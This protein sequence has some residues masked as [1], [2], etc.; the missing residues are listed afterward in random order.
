MPALLRS[1][2]PPALVAGSHGPA[3][4]SAYFGVR[5]ESAV[6]LLEARE[7]S[8]LQ[9]EE[10]LRKALG[11]QRSLLNSMLEPS[12]ALALDLRTYV[13]PETGS[14][15]V[16]LLGRSWSPDAATAEQRA[17]AFAH[18]IQ[19][20]LPRHVT[21]VAVEDPAELA[22]LIWPFGA[23]AVTETGAI[24]RREVTALPTRP[25]AKV[26]YYFSVLPF[27]WAEDDWISLYSTLSQ[28][29]VRM[30]LSVGLLPVA[31]PR[32]FGERLRTMA[33]YYG[34]LASED[35]VKGGLYHGQQKLAPD[36]FAVDAQKVFNDYSRR[37]ADRAY[38]MRIALCAEGALPPGVPEAVAAAVSPP[39]VAGGS[40]LTQDRTSSAYE[41]REARQEPE[42]SVARWNL[43]A[44]D[45]CTYGGAAEIWQ[46]PDPPSADLRVLCNLGDA[47]DASCAFRFPVAVDGTVPGFKVRRGQ[48]GHVESYATSGPAIVLGETTAG[49]TLAL[50]LGSL[51]KHALV[52]GGTGSG[53]TTTVLEI[54][55]QLW[56]EHEVP[57]LVI[58]PVNADADDYRKLLT[59]PGFE[60]LEVFTVGDEGVH[61]LRFNPFEVPEGALVSEHMANLLSCFKAAF[62][63]WEPLPSIYEEA[64]NLTYMSAGILP[65]ERPDG[66]PRDWP[67]A[68]EF[69]KAMGEATA[70]L[71]YAGEVKSN[72]EAASI[73]RAQQLASGTCASTF[74]TT[75]SL[76]LAALLDHPVVIELK[77]LGAGDEQSL[78][79]AFL[80][81]AMTE[82]YQAV[83]G[84]SPTLRHVT[85]IEEAHRL[86]ARP[87]GGG[88]QNT[89][90]AKEKAAEGFANTLAENRK[91]GEGV[92]IAEQLPTKLV[93][94]AVKNTNLKMMHRLTA[95]DERKYLGETMGFDDSQSRFA[96]RLQT[97]EALVYADDFA[98]ATLVG[99]KPQLA[100]TVP[101]VVARQADPPFAA[102]AD[103]RAQCLY[104]GAALAVVRQPA[105][106]KRIR[107][108][109]GALEQEGLTSAQIAERWDALVGALRGTV[110]SYPVLPQE[111]PGVSD[112]AYCIFLHALA[113]KNMRF[114][115]RWASAVAARLGLGRRA[116]EEVGV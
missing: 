28:A 43:E 63:L 72:I 108:A 90:Q 50:P 67:T 33:T 106:G 116:R 109:A 74:L 35:T 113:T 49:G 30:F 60:A 66:S 110:T 81:N 53:K 83:R 9:R 61:P 34:R 56:A 15:D 8:G 7:Y 27:N 99:V 75:R 88:D 1:L 85:V 51:T 102:C 100:S 95:E 73:R 114:S 54:L 5:I 22:E 20:S 105:N 48:F 77:S 97:G 98:E 82:H 68:V 12:L 93:Q 19:A 80:L 45:F 46:R 38:A 24:T 58:E 37:Y 64:L 103:C 115:P 94:D 11:E 89:A 55:R 16:V 17:G 76:D 71:G 59:E 6:N 87:S 111:E 79:I 44:I 31:L 40:H 2:P 3:G 86:L 57:F 41:I 62:G 13:R 29:G 23:S 26:A 42:R 14:L 4:A 52:A 96:T 25:D 112:A 21:G 69:M 104:R 92:I 65:T 10:R 91:Y 78:M 32:S 36:A 70:D 47:R 107:L 18:Q 84:A 39:E 101:A